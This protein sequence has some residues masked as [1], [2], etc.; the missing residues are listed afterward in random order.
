MISAQDQALD[1]VAGLVVAQPPPSQGQ[2]LKQGL[3]RGQG[4]DSG[5]SDYAR[6][7]QMRLQ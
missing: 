3:E 2:G 4:F 1:V 6:P 7:A 5:Y